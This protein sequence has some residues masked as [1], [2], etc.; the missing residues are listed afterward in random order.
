MPVSCLMQVPSHYGNAQAM[1]AFWLDDGALAISY[2][3][4]DEARFISRPAS[5]AY[6]LTFDAKTIFRFSRSA[7]KMPR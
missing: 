3:M 1:T 7:D 6:T 4:R 5:V 2:G